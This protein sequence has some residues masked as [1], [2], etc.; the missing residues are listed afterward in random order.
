MENLRQRE[1]EEERRKNEKEGNNR[2]ERSPGVEVTASHG[3]PWHLTL[4]RNHWAPRISLKQWLRPGAP[5]RNSQSCGETS[6]D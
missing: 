2:K 5:L 3:L 4:F 1:R 6:H